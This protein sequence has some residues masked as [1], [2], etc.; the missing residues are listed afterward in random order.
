MTVFFVCQRFTGSIPFQVVPYLQTT[1]MVL[2]VTIAI[3]DVVF[4]RVLH[5]VSS[6]DF[7][8]FCVSSLLS[9]SRSNRFQLVPGSSSLFQ[10]VS[11]LSIW[12]KLVL[13]CS[14]F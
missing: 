9:P 14:L 8:V 10:V 4:H 11:V 7:L 2:F 6:Y 3:A 13:A 5:T 1:E 12:F